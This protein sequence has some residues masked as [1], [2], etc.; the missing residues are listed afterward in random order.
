MPHL[1]ITF[2]LLPRA[3]TNT[4]YSKYNL[5]WRKKHVAIFGGRGVI[6]VRN[7]YKAIISYWN[8]EK[9]GGH[10]TKVVKYDTYDTQEFRDF[11]FTGVYR[12]FE[13][14]D[15]WIKFGKDLYF[16]FYEELKDN[17]VEEI[18]KLLLY[19]GLEVDEGRLACLSNHLV[20]SFH[21][22]SKDTEDPFT[23][24]H[25]LMISSVVEKVDRILQNVLARKMPS[26][27]YQ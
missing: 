27:R 24:E 25:N 6:V 14:I 11:V 21:R 15:D 20:G 9:T 18:R 10:H 1:Y 17:P 16:V 8:W 26:Y 22:V 13:L 19:L 12:W 4:L 7:P 2:L 23:E 5:T 3:I